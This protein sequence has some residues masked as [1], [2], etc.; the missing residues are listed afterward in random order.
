MKHTTT[1]CYDNIAYIDALN[2]SVID[3]CAQ[4]LA[5]Y[6]EAC[7]SFAHD[8]REWGDLMPFM[9][10]STDGRASWIETSD[11][12]HGGIDV[13]WAFHLSD[14]EIRALAPAHLLAEARL[15]SPECE[16]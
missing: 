8:S 10:Y 5:D 11:N 15:L 1:T 13:S 6:T 4:T 12:A 16:E 9:I 3:E 14:E 7:I 2:Q